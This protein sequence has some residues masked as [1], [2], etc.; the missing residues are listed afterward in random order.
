MLWDN[1]ATDPT[2]RRGRN[3][4]TTLPSKEGTTYQVLR[5]FIWTPRPELVLTEMIVTWSG[6]VCLMCQMNLALTVW[7]VSYSS[8]L[9]P[10]TCTE[11]GCMD[12]VR[13]T[14]ADTEVATFGS[15]RQCSTSRW[16]SSS[17][18]HSSAR[19]RSSTSPFSPTLLWTPPPLA[20]RRFPSYLTQCIYRSLFDSQLPHDI[21]NLIFWSVIVNNKLTILW[22][23]DLCEPTLK[24][25]CVR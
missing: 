14:A 10:S 7:Y 17:S 3:I 5:A 4:G 11:T 24:T 22:G 21:V 16:E 2:A 12:H 23:V 9:I 19:H 6:L 20:L 8:F 15:K 25:L 1:I 18:I 13:W